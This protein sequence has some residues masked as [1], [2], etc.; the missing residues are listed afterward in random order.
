MENSPCLYPAVNDETTACGSSDRISELRSDLCALNA[1]YFFDECLCIREQMLRLNA[2]ACELENIDQRVVEASRPYLNNM[3][4]WLRDAVSTVTPAGLIVWIPCMLKFSWWPGAAEFFQYIKYVQDECG[5]APEW[6]QVVFVE[7]PIAF[8]FVCRDVGNGT[9]ASAEMFRHGVDIFFGQ[10]ASCHCVRV[11]IGMLFSIGFDHCL[12]ATVDAWRNY[13]ASY[14]DPAIAERIAP[15][16]YTFERYGGVRLKYA[17]YPPLGDRMAGCT[18][19]ATCATIHL[20]IRGALRGHA[21]SPSVVRLL[22]EPAPRVVDR[23]QFPHSATRTG[24]APAIEK[25]RGRGRGRRHTLA[26]P[27]RLYQLYVA[28]NEPYCNR[29]YIS[30]TKPDLHLGYQ[31]H[32]YDV[33]LQELTDAILRLENTPTD[34]FGMYHLDATGYGLW[35]SQLCSGA[36]A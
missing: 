11:D 3:Y 20:G 25:P 16:P 13:V 2:V 12:D 32:V 19:T 33:S 36:H 24:P 6:R 29:V 17:L 4:R 18:D 28:W 7:Q 27:G 35:I 30:P 15:Y 10:G 34:H 14:M 21:E 9:P 1:K 31:I 8:T 23:P 5:Y 26:M 22:P